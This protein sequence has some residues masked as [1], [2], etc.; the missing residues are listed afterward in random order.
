MI[1][2]GSGPPVVLIPGLQGRWEWMRP[3]VDA[4]ARRNRVLSFS[5]CDERSSLF[6][7]VPA[8]GFENYIDQ[9]SAVLDRAGLASATLIGVSY[10]GLIAAEFAARFPERTTALILASALHSAWQPDARARLYLRAPR[11]LSPL[12]VA[13]APGR[14]NPE[15]AAAL[16]DL[17][18]RVRF[19]VEHGI[20]V[21]RAPMSP[22]KMA[23]RVAWAA[24]HS[25]ADLRQLKVPALVVTGETDL[26]RVVPADHT[27]QYL[28]E[29]PGACHEV[30]SRTGH[31]GIVTRPDTFAE[32]LGRFMDGHRIPA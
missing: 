22:T 19:M 26:D 15:I 11:L 24:A 8:R 20:R 31:I 10:G 2:I 28:S 14:L 4:L 21:A 3:T 23:R 6:P 25:F 7:C 29:L 5:L 17:R 18:A 32:M 9:V 16:P 30:L 12:F 1:D 27:R 13:T